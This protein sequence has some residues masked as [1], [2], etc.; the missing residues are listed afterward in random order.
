MDT[1]PSTRSDVKPE[2]RQVRRAKE[3]AAGKAFQARHRQMSRALREDLEEAG[4]RAEERE[5]QRNLGAQVEGILGR[6]NGQRRDRHDPTEV[7]ECCCNRCKTHL[8]RNFFRKGSYPRSLGTLAGTLHLNVPRVRCQCGGDVTIIYCY[9]LP[10][11]RRFIDVDENI[12]TLSA[13]C[14][15]VREI[16]VILDER[17]QRVSINT[18]SKRIRSVAELS[19]AEFSR[20]ERVPPI[21]QLDGIFTREA[22]GTGEFFINKRGHRRERKK[23]KKAALVVAWGIYP[24]T[25]ER[26]LLGWEPGHEEDGKTCLKLLKRLDKLGICWRNGL[27]LFIH[28]GGGGFVAAFEQITFGPVEHQRCIFHKMRNV[29]DAV[30][31]DG[32]MSR[33]EKRERRREVLADLEEVWTGGSEEAVRGR[34]EK[35]AAAWQEKEP[36]AVAK[37][38]YEF[39]STLAYLQVQVQ[40]R[41][42]GRE[43]EARFLRTTSS[44]ERTNRTIREKARKAGVFQTR[45]GLRANCYLAAGC[46]GKNKPGRLRAWVAKLRDGE[47][48]L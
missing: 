9:F 8:R 38:R 39:D 17:G 46:V 14:L 18:I 25:G 31:G 32:K 10:Y 21:V 33:E 26:V 23:V 3:R 34:L 28:D 22:E 40:A 1:L 11:E 6:A 37:L 2:S 4:R 5:V 27:R 24:D 48:A 15:S 35:F 7:K 30:K 29:L 41:A 16:E 45:E 43:W 42:E 36:E 47:H 12:L 13:L 20:L 44:L 19:E